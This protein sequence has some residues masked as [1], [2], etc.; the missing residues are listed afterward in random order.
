MKK[1]I[2]TL[3]SETDILLL[4][5]MED[6]HLLIQMARI[7]LPEDQASILPHTLLQEVQ[8]DKD[9]DHNKKLDDEYD[10]A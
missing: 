7:L 1:K 8:K 5:Q 10:K 6:I 9:Q 2:K 3:S 4:T